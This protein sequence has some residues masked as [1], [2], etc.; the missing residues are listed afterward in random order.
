MAA[1]P[2]PSSADPAASATSSPPAAC[3]PLRAPRDPQPGDGPFFS[4]G[5]TVRRHAGGPTPKVD[6]LQIECPRNGIRL[7][8]ADRT[9]FAAI[10]A[11]VLTLFI[12]A[13]YPYRFPAAPPK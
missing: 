2:P 11:E 3:A 10:A 1:A 12:E 7:T 8:A 4:G 6:G 13:H 9:R 5:Y